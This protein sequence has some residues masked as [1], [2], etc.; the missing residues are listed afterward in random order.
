MCSYRIEADYSSI[1]EREP[2]DMPREKMERLGPSALTD[3]E[4][5]MLIIGSGSSRRDVEELAGELL[6]KMDQSPSITSDEIMKISGIGQ[7]KASAISAAMELG[8]R[9][10]HRKTVTIASPADIYREIRHYSS[11]E[12]ENLIVLLLNGAHEMIGSFVATVGLLN[13]TIIHPREVF[14]SAIKERAAAIVIAH[15]HPSGN[16]IPSEEDKEVTIRL[17]RAGEILGI[18]ILDH[19]VFTDERFYS[20]VEHGIL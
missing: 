10:V 20:F 4:L 5:L 15:N 13:R 2:H 8:R 16:L 7:A 12:Q 9:R 6:E 19:L 18:R 3:K 17:K 11:R 14:A 1:K